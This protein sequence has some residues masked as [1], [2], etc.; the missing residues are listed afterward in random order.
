MGEVVFVEN[1]FLFNNSKGSKLLFDTNDVLSNYTGTTNHILIEKNGQL[2]GFSIIKNNINVFIADVEEYKKIILIRLIRA[3]MQF[4]DSVNVAVINNDEYELALRISKI[5]TYFHKDS[6]LY[7]Y[8]NKDNNYS[9]DNYVKTI[10]N[11]SKLTLPTDLYNTVVLFLL[12]NVSFMDKLIEESILSFCDYG[13]LF[14]VTK[15]VLLVKKYFNNYCISVENIYLDDISVIEIDVTYNIKNIIYTESEKYAKENIKKIVSTA[16]LELKPLLKQ[17]DNDEYDILIADIG[18]IE[19]YV[20]IIKSSFY[21]K[22]LKYNI[23]LL[24]EAMIEYRLGFGK[25]EDIEIAYEK[26]VFSLEN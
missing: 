10:G 6:M 19:G 1:F 15:D 5:L 14:I 7:Y 26:V 22:D 11:L 12:D 9:N 23:N 16:L 18:K 24:K 8:S 21:N 4:T 20:N 2:E 25:F 13:K 3:I 17:Y